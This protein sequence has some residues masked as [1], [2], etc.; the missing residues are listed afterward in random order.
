MSD[1]SRLWAARLFAYGLIAL[2][3][4]HA[5]STV[6]SATVSSLRLQPATLSGPTS[7]GTPVPTLAPKTRPRRRIVH[8]VTRIT[9]KP[10]DAVVCLAQVIYYEAHREP[11]AGMQA[12]AATVFNRMSSE[13]HQYP[14]SVCGVV[15]QPYQYSWTLDTAK[16]M[17]RPPTYY[18]SLAEAFLSEQ[19]TIR[20]D[21]PVT[22]FHRLDVRPRWARTLD[23]WGAVGHHKFYAAAVM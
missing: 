23:Y 9:Q 20:A 18:I 17:R 15:Y 19:H 6:Q 8:H 4:L 11:L 1:H 21:F 16:W 7:T 3:L 14:T 13:T 12:V 5:P 22:H 2:S 10:T